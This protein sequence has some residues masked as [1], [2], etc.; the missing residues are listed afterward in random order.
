MDLSTRM[1]VCF[2]SSLISER[3]AF[4]KAMQMLKEL[5]I[6]INSIRL[7]RYYS[8][9]CYVNQF[10]NSTIYIIPRK[11]SKLGH[12][13]E[14]LETM[15][16]FLEDTMNYLKEYF[17]RVNSENGFAQDKKM[18]GWKISQKIEERIDTALFCKMIWHDLINL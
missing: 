14:W 10:P 4:D 13:T 18:F 2:G 9:P 11:N 15:K 16:R 12:G 1:Y 17:Q 7:D 5:N 3:K 8:F 6:K